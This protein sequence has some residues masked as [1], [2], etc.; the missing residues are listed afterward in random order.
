MVEKKIKKTLSENKESIFGFFLGNVEGDIHRSIIFNEKMC[1][2]NIVENIIK[3]LCSFTTESNIAKYATIELSRT[4]LTFVTYGDVVYIL[5]H[6]IPKKA[7]FLELIENLSELFQIK[8]RGKFF[9][10]DPQQFFVGASAAFPKIMDEFFEEVKDTQKR[11]IENQE[12]KA[13]KE[14]EKIEERKKI[15]KDKEEEQKKEQEKLENMVAE[16]FG[17]AKDE[18]KEKVVLEDETAIKA[19]KDASSGLQNSFSGIEHLIIVKHDEKVANIFFHDGKI[20]ESFVEKTLQIIQMYLSQ[21]LDLM[22]SDIPEENVIE[23]PMD[24]KLVF[25][26]MDEKHFL[27]I[28]AKSNV[29]LVLL[30]PV[31]TRIAKKLS[32]HFK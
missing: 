23:L 19:F 26:P 28:I 12:Q 25:T 7:T 27:Y 3:A 2:E 32:L 21:V 14:K 13:L 11:L 16:F 10:S 9:S 24:K 22:K 6:N 30:I 29:D 5:S 8:S 20:E 17:E 4:K 18:K 31:F 1:P 15:Q